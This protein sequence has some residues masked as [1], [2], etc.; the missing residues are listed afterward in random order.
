MARNRRGGGRRFRRQNAEYIWTAAY[1]DGVIKDYG[2]TDAYQILGSL[3]WATSPANERATLMRIVGYLNGY[4]AGS[5]NPAAPVPTGV[6]YVVYLTDQDDGIAR[7]ANEI[8]TY[9][10][11][12][13][14]I[15]SY[16]PAVVDETAQLFNA[17]GNGPSLQFD[18]KVKR[19]ITHQTQ[20]VVVTGQTSSTGFEGQLIGAESAAF[21][22]LVKIS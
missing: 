20:I 17:R 1:F 11:D 14:Q 18:I 6:P 4:A 22:C 3:D 10:E 19:K 2:N 9:A 5:F 7:A 15:G 21:R 12:V 16:W 8:T 13:M